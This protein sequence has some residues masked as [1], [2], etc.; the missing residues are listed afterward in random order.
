MFSELDGSSTMTASVSTSV[1]LRGCH[2]C[3]GASRTVTDLLFHF[4]QSRAIANGGLSADDI[5]NIRV[6]FNESISSGV[7]LFE[8]I[9]Q[10]CMNASE[11]NAHNLFSRA[12]ILSTLLLAC[13]RKSAE[14]AFAIQ[15]EH[16]GLDWL[17][18]FFYAF[19]QYFRQHANSDLEARLI[20]AYVNAAATFKSNLTV[21]NLLN[22][23]SVQEVLDIYVKPFTHMINIDEVAESISADT[24]CYIASK[25]ILAGPN[26][27]KTTADEIKRFLTMLPRETALKLHSVKVA[28]D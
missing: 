6:Q 16:C 1:N 12:T 22:E 23:V 8:A 7:D 21:S 5:V 20:G 10:Q 14:H 9:H 17:D 24:N 27:A 13:G 26:I 18:D 11:H 19:A 15:I 25:K 2:H 28:N 4:L 3:I